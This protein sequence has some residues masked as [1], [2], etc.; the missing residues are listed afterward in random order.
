MM[1]TSD[2]HSRRLRISNKSACQVILTN[3][4]ENNLT[5]ASIA[6]LIHEQWRGLVRLT[7]SEEVRLQQTAPIVSESAQAILALPNDFAPR[8]LV[9]WILIAT[10]F[11]ELGNCGTLEMHEFL[12]ASGMFLPGFGREGLR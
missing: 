2:V 6:L 7:I 11:G 12:Q 4:Q 9:Y 10:Q 1:M 8:T 3:T 5:V